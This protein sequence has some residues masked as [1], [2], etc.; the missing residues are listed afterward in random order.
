MKCIKLI[1]PT[2]IKK[3]R[4]IDDSILSDNQTIIRKLIDKKEG[5]ETLSKFCICMCPTFLPVDRGCI[6]RL[7][8]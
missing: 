1:T 3:H 5:L 2:H 8:A 7:F 6:M 4:K